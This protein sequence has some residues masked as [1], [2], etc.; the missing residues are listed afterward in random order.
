MRIQLDP[1]WLIDGDALS[2]NLIQLKTVTGDNAKGRA[3]K[4]ENIGK[5]R[6]ETFGF[7]G[8]VQQ[9]CLAYLKARQ[10]GSA[11]TTAEELIALTEQAVTAII[12]ATKGIPRSVLTKS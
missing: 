4:P 7:Y 8:T 9:A 12:E 10:N 6:E 2:V 1:E 5:I 11:C 3:P